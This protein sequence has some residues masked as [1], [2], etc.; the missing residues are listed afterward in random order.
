MIWVKSISVGLLAVVIAMPV[1]F[2]VFS[3]FLKARS[4]LPTISIDIVSLSKN[5]IVYFLLLAVF[6]LGFFWEY[7]RLAPN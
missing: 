7:R 1:G 2:V 5:M 3:L 6:L 4:G